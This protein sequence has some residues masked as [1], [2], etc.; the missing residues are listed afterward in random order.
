MLPINFT[1]ASYVV[2]NAMG[3]A[4]DALYLHDDNDDANATGAATIRASSYSGTPEWTLTWWHYLPLHTRARARESDVL[5]Y[6]PTAGATTFRV[7]QWESAQNM[8]LVMVNGVVAAHTFSSALRGQWA[9]VALIY[10]RTNGTL[11]FVINGV[12]IS[13]DT[14]CPCCVTGTCAKNPIN[15]TA[16]VDV[17]TIVLNSALQGIYWDEIRYFAS[18]LSP[19]S[20]LSIYNFSRVLYAAAP[21]SAPTVGPTSAPSAEGG[22]PSSEPS[23][24]PTAEP[25]FV[26]DR[27]FEQT[28]VMLR[29]NGTGSAASTV[30]DSST[31]RVNYTNSSDLVGQQLVMTLDNQADTDQVVAVE[32]ILGANGVPIGLDC[33]LDEAIYGTAVAAF[34]AT[35][36]TTPHLKLTIDTSTFDYYTGTRSVLLCING[37]W[38]SSV[39]VC[40]DAGF[41]HSEI[42]NP[43]S[44]QSALCHLTHVVVTDGIADAV[45]VTG[46]SCSASGQSE[47]DSTFSAFLWLS[48]ACLA[49]IVFLQWFYFGRGDGKGYKTLG[50]D[51]TSETEG[52]ESTCKTC[53][54]AFIAV[55]GDPFLSVVVAAPILLLAIFQYR[56]HGVHGTNVLWSTYEG[57]TAVDHLWYFYGV[58][59]FISFIRVFLKVFNKKCCGC[60]GCTDD[61]TSCCGVAGYLGTLVQLVFLMWMVFILYGLSSLGYLVDLML[62]ILTIGVT[63]AAM[64]CVGVTTFCNDDKT[65]EGRGCERALTDRKVWLLVLMGMAAAFYGVMTLRT[66]NN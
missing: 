61:K 65:K 18:A 41:N 39:A 20:V 53:K 50:E 32:P 45:C 52:T 35:A 28:V 34:Q 19:T 6:S 56:A 22:A 47:T 66:C 60:C 44:V 57:D 2:R 13:S 1:S 55:I 58:I 16:L 10:S 54:K 23:S 42:V 63:L 24:E 3:R 46:C 43:T 30:G 40:S 12:P 21:S 51:T 15:G 29:A 9:H 8:F 27:T 38:I 4:S 17:G 5:M 25:T 36:M 14:A 49:S 59:A 26:D 37:S 11:S 62:V 64:G 48:F 31:G 7:V 33:P